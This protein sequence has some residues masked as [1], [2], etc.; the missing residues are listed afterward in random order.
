M[1]PKMMS[2]KSLKFQA[3]H[4]E[5]FGLKITAR[6]PE[7]GLVSSCVCRFCIVFGREEKVGAK[8][9]ATSRAKHFDCFRTDNYLQHLQQQ[10]PLKWAAYE[11]LLSSAERDVFFKAVPVPFV[12]SLEAHFERDGPLYF[13]VNESIVKDIIGGLLFHPDD[14]EGVTID[15]DFSAGWSSGGAGERFPTLRQFCGDLASTFPNTATVESDFS[16]I[17]W[18]KDEFRKCLTDFSL[19]G[20]MH[21]K[22]FD[23]LKSLRSSF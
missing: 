23:R 16:V 22:Q 6:D 7:S 13:T 5:K 2:K 4:E 1:P 10:H 15:T 14:M 9:K 11:E 12:N 20:I 17:G 3:K 8:R 19:E 21:C 18:E